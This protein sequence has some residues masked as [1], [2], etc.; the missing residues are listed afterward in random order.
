MRHALLLGLWLGAA[1]CDGGPVTP[2]TGG[3]P[4]DLRLL[5]LPT[6]VYG[7][8]ITLRMELRNRTAD[9]LR[10]RLE[11]TSTGF[12]FR[13]IDAA[14]QVRWYRTY[15]HARIDEPWTLA[16]PPGEAMLFTEVWKLGD[17]LGRALPPGTYSVEGEVQLADPPDTLRT[18]RAPV[19]IPG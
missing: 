8:A 12:D 16:L 1:A 9:S 14:G 11:H 6:T 4:Y 15:G 18:G 10:L 3:T 13:V 7:A 19:A 2:D 5:G 17:S